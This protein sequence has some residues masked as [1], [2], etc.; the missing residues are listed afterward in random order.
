[1]NVLSAYQCIVNHSAPHWQCVSLLISFLSSSA[2]LLSWYLIFSALQS[3]LLLCCTPIS[4]SPLQ[5]SILL[6]PAPQSSLCL[7]NHISFIYSLIC[8][9]NS[10]PPGP[11]TPGDYF[12]SLNVVFFK[13]GLFFFLLMLSSHLF[14]SP[15]FCSLLI[16]SQGS[17]MCFDLPFFK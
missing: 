11:S 14:S 9:I 1:M 7:S 5:S 10:P 17:Y 3:S 4:S 2:G 8:F 6:S 12:I 13:W 16:S 15:F